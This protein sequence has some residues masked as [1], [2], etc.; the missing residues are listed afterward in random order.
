MWWCFVL[1]RVY[2]TRGRKERGGSG[3]GRRV[4]GG[5]SMVCIR[6]SVLVFGFLFGV[7]WQ[8]TPAPGK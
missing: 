1:V 4:G 2:G 8:H 7:G 3:D 5:G 6:C